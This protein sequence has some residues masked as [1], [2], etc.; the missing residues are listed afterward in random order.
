MAKGG[1]RA[2]AGRPSGKISASAAAI[3][4]LAR[5]LS[6]EALSIVLATMR[7]EDLNAGLR[8]QAANVILER[9]Y[10][11]PSTEAVVIDTNPEVM[12]KLIAGEITAL[13]AAMEL[14]KDGYSI[15]ETVMMLLKAEL[16]MVE[17]PEENINPAPP[18]EA[19][20]TMKQYTEFVEWQ[21]V[22]AQ[23]RSA[24]LIAKIEAEG[25]AYNDGEA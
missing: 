25:Q 17:P 8:L 23:A 4:S 10:G 12:D 20:I 2:G 18:K 22:Q 21:K 7:D 11:R 1:K 16:R 19:A 5:D 14:E 9:G 6:I 13:H 3:R 15:P 24:A